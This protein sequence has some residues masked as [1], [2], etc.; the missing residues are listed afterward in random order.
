MLDDLPVDLIKQLSAYIRS[1]QEV[2]SPVSRSGK[3]TRKAL[4]TYKDWLA[5]QDIPGPILRSSRIESRHGVKLSPPGPGRKKDKFGAGLATSPPPS[6]AVRPQIDVRPLQ[7]SAAAGTNE[8]EVFMMDDTVPSLALDQI[9]RTPS[10]SKVG[11]GW[12]VATAPKYAFTISL[13]DV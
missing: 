11:G 13:F 9:Q 4:E 12:K 8:G 3:L 1:E 5:L 7:P 2:K 6:P 10:S